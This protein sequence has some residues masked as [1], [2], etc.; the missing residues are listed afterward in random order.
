[1]A[2]VTCCESLVFCLVFLTCHFLRLSLSDLFGS[3]EWNN[4]SLFWVYLWFL[5][6]QLKAVR[7][8]LHCFLLNNIWKQSLPELVSSVC[9]HTRWQW[10]SCG[11]VLW[12]GESPS[13]LLML[14]SAVKTC[15]CFSGWTMTKSKFQWSVSGP[16]LP[17]LKNLPVD[18]SSRWHCPALRGNWKH[19]SASN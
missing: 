2:V 4:I 10:N 13:Y 15:C 16:F 5:L 14:G 1:M 11:G 9:A 6:L 7:V 12:F 8:K 17:L 19:V 18:L 3:R